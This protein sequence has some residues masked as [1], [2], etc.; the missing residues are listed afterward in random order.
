MSTCS[1]IPNKFQDKDPR[2]LL[3]HFP[4]LPAVKLAKLYQEYCFFKQ[5][6]LAED[7]AHKMG[8]I[9]VPYE[10]M[11]WQRKKAFGNDRKV[12]VGRNS[13]FMMQQNELTRT[14]KRKLEE[15]LE[16]LNYSS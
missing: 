9:L 15:Y 10:C 13:Y 14:E 4:T 8:F 3:Y 11:H 1:V 16:E 12:K 5:L 6:E 2:Q 7:M